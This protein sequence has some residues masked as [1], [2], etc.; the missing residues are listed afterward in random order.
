MR[1][2]RESGPCL[3]ITHTKREKLM[4]SDVGRLI[5]DI[6]VIARIS[7]QKVGQRRYL[8]SSGRLKIMLSET[9]KLLVLATFLPMSDAFTS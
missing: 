7:D 8:F 6:K 5:S 9:S 1:K 3:L 2:D 4:E